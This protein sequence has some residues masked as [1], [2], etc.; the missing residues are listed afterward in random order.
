MTPLD[1]KKIEDVSIPTAGALGMGTWYNTERAWI[2]QGWL[3]RTWASHREVDTL[4]GT[5]P[6]VELTAGVSLTFV[7]DA[8]HSWV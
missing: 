6:A 8:T 5:P 1:W 4:P 7:P 2:P 3:V